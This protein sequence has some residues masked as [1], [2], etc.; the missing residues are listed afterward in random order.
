MTEI[1][2]F[3][4]HVPCEIESCALARWNTIGSPTKNH[5][6][7]KQR[8]MLIRMRVRNVYALQQVVTYIK[9]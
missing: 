7:R 4:D 9:L 3:R 8:N 1:V 6:H 5:E 2:Q